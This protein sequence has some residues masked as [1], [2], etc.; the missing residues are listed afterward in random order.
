MSATHVIE[1][2]VNLD[3][4][5]PQI[6]GDAQQR[7]LDAGALDVWTTAIGMKKQ[8]P[9]VMLSVLCEPAK[10]EELT[11]LILKLTGSFGVRFREWDRT[12]LD[13]RH[14]TVQTAYGQ[15][16]IKVG[17]INGNV[18][19]ARPEF[20]DVKRLANEA[21]VPVRQVMEAA[22]AAARAMDGNHDPSHD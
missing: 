3:D 16:R 5:S 19:V 18:L 11:R 12:V 1:L 14:E 6:I 17:S 4:V 13:R 20:E 21:G 2:A 15:V 10:Q 8:R 7:L 9:G 22:E